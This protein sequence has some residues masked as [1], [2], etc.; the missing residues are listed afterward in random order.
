MAVGFDAA[1]RV[2]S[3]LSGIGK[4]DKALSDQERTDKLVADLG[5]FWVPL[6]NGSM[7]ELLAMPL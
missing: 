6:P 5:S 4:D 1:A 7:V 2:S 3:L